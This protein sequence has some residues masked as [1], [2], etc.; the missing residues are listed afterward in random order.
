MLA[1]MGVD[2]LLI[3]GFSTSGCVRASALDALQHGFAPFVVR[4]ACGDRAE[5]PHEANLFDLQAKYAE[6][7]GEARAI[8]LLAAA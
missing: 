4:D 7:I 1:A 8:E 3:T 6:V 5:G 2:C